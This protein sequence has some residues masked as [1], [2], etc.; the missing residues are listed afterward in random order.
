[1][2]QLN[3][4]HC[5][6][7]RLFSCV[8]NQL[9]LY[10]SGNWL[11]PD[12]RLI[13]NVLDYMQAYPEFWHHP[14]EDILFAEL[15]ERDI[16]QSYTVESLLV[17]H[18]ELESATRF[19]KS[20]YKDSIESDCLPSEQLIDDTYEYLDRQISHLSTEKT[21]IYPVVDVYLSDEVVKN[22]N[23]THREIKDP[24]FG[25]ELENKY[26]GLFQKIR[27]TDQQMQRDGF[28]FI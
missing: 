3:L 19:I 22:L 21:A 13:L 23:L 6:F 11:L 18:Q 5:R 26:D 2:K 28:S 9:D 4:D 17:E 27:E 14:S 16:P 10:R 24:L 8:Q 25:S 15:L 20:A 12:P 7:L 1:M